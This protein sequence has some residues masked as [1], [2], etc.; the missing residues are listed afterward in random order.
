[1]FEFARK[2]SLGA[3]VISVSVIGL[4]LSLGMCAVGGG[5]LVP[6]HVVLNTLGCTYFSDRLS[7]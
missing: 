6:D 7:G 1:M 4:L 2:W 3:K 5:F